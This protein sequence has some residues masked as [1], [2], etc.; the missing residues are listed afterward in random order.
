MVGLTC[1]TPAPKS[2]SAL[3]P[4]SFTEHFQVAFRKKLYHSLAEVQADLDEW[5]RHY[6]HERTHS[7]KYCFG[8]TPCQTFQATKQLAK[9]KMLDTLFVAPTDEHHALNQTPLPVAV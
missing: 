3:C 9:D 6:N 4:R 1:A 8:R 2:W 7:G 5:L